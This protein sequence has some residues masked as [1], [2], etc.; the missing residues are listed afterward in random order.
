[1]SFESIITHLNAHHSE[2]LVDL[3]RKFSGESEIQN[4]TLKSVDYEG[5]EL[6]YNGSKSLHIDFP[7]KANDETLKNVII[8][9]CMSVKKAWI[10]A[11]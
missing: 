11:R 2:N 9:L 1:M 3:V 5:L 10:M 6:V 7:A 4:A 8:E